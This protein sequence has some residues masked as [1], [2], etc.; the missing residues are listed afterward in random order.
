MKTDVDALHK[1]INGEVK[2]RGR[3]HTFARCHILA[4][5]VELSNVSHI[6]F[7]V[8]SYVDLKF[9]I[10]MIKEVFVDHEIEFEQIKRDTIKTK[11]K[12]TISKYVH[13]ITFS[14]FDLYTK[15][16]VFITV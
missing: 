16:M 15:G 12:F 14:D 3:G 2:G 10:P 11:N 4:G 13:L 7:P 6:V 9:L 1:V 5:N 8:E